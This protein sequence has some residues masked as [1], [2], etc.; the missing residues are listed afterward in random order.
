MDIRNEIDKVK[1]MIEKEQGSPAPNQ[2]YV[3]KLARTL[4]LMS[5]E[6]PNSQA[7]PQIK[8]MP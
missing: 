2:E 5:I 7:R 3:K 8:I 4:M 6:L 1:K